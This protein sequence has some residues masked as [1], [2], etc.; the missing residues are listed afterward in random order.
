MTPLSVALCAL[1]TVAS[2]A[3]I[4]VNFGA[5]PDAQFEPYAPASLTP[6]AR[7]FASDAPVAAVYREHAWRGSASFAYAMRVPPG[8]YTAR[9]HFAEVNA[10]ACAVGAR[11][12]GVQVAGE[13]VMDI[14]VFAEVGCNRPYTLDFLDV[15]AKDGRIVFRFVKVNEQSAMISALEALAVSEVAAATPSPIATRTPSSSPALKVGIQ[16]DGFV[17][18]NCGG[19]GD[20]DVDVVGTKVY[21]K[22]AAIKGTARDEL[23]TSSRYG[24]DFT[25]KFVLPAGSYDVSLG[26]AEVNPKYC[27]ASNPRVFN[28]TING[29]LVPEIMNYN[30]FGSVGCNTIEYFTF[31]EK[32]VASGT[33]L[34]IQFASGTGGPASI[35]YIR[36]RPTSIGCRPLSSGGQLGSFDHAAHSIAG[37]YPPR[38]KADSPKS[39]VDELGQGFVTVSI[40]GVGSHTHYFDPPAGIAGKL[41]YWEW[42]NV[43][44]GEF[45]SNEPSFSYDFPLGT[46]R[47]SLFVIDNSCTSDLSETTITVVPS[48]EK[49]SASASKGEELIAKDT[50]VEADKLSDVD[51]VAFSFGKMKQKDG[52]N[53][54]SEFATCIRLGGDGKIYMGTLQGKVVVLEYD[55][56]TF[57]VSSRCSSR[58]LKDKRFQKK[59]APASR[60]ILGLVFDPRDTIPRPYVSS[61]T[62]FWR[63][64]RN[65]DASNAAAWRNGAVDRLKPGRDATDPSICLIYDK[66]II[67]N[68]PVSNHDHGVNGMEFSQTGDLFI[69]VGGFTNSG[70]PSYLLG[71]VWEP[72]NAA[73]ILHAKLSRGTAFD[74]TI[75]YSSPF[76]PKNAKVTGGDL[77]ILAT[78]LRNPFCLLLHS[79]NDL[80]ATD[81]SCNAGYGNTSE[82]C[83]EQDSDEP[84]PVNLRDNWPGTVPH[85]SG[86]DM[87]STSRPDKVMHITAGSYYGHPNLNRGEC[88]WIDPFDG[89]TGLDKPPPSNYRPPL[90]TMTS[91][92]NGIIEYTAG[93]VFGGALQGELIMSSFN[94]GDTYRMGVSNGKKTT[95]LSVLSKDGGLSVAMNSRGDLIFPRVQMLDIF[96]LRPKV[97]VLESK[98]EVS[99][100]AAVPFRHGKDGGTLVQIGG[101]NFGD[102]GATVT[103]GGNDCPVISQTTR[104][105]VCTVPAARSPGALVNI[106]V[107]VDG[108]TGLSAVAKKGLWYMQV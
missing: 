79:E 58:P 68:L 77:S 102:S 30:I 59:G 106:A 78:G 96:F 86:K 93:N 95:E 67:S 25:Y 47:L 31:R 63:E 6:G 27:T 8:V 69:A 14:D 32:T 62:L 46:T 20:D 44:T 64:K 100:T 65:I 61:Q 4:R 37:S 1:L 29:A 49:P 66:R 21:S 7:I 104:S 87:Y 80:Y 34:S 51:P 9:L 22:K 82:T 26:F 16:Y 35:S 92:I 11:V 55:M 12:F 88:A 2:A 94:S 90:E 43:D 108:D 72:P 24:D 53:S 36:I 60:D 105:I 13:S 84:Y 81:N 45:L 76:D 75:T 91:S 5:L 103:I 3:P 48:T 41:E 17:A 39:Y 23:Y 99:V 107:T 15:D 28:V 98:A 42:V 71:N 89:K 38:T 83:D 33:R 85:G 101:Y 18:V 70:L 19:G 97:P 52:T 10:S 40:D 56:D 73:S 54:S 50:E 57:E 74:G